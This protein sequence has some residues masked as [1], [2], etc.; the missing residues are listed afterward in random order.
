M[1][2]NLKPLFIF[3]M[4][5]AGSTLAQRILASHEEIAT[6]SEPWILLP[7]LFTL[8]EQGIYAEY[9][10]KEVVM[11]IEDFYKQLPN[12]KS[13]YLSEIKTLVMRLYAKAAKDDAKYFLDK[14]PRYHFVIEDIIGLFPEAKYIFL[15][16]HPLAVVA[17]IM[18]TWCHGKWNIYR[19]Q[20][21]IFDGLAHL[22]TAYEK[23]ASKSIAVQYE[24]L[25]SNPE[26]EFNRLFNYLEL[27]FKQELLTNF[28]KI[29]LQG[30]QGDPTGVKEYQYFSK[31]PLE[32]WKITMS[33][34]I[35]KAWCR[36][37]LR[38]IGKERLAVMGYDLDQM[39]VE[40]DSIPSNLRLMGSD[41]VRITYGIPFR[42]I[43]Y[44]LSNPIPIQRS[45][46]E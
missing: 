1:R 11:A 16:R 34:P 9:D 46:E 27:P 33:N 38:W 19:Y 17:S 41:V 14:T 2:T 29:Q 22:I 3:S 24:K 36:Y 31:E 44:Y 30:R 15:W 42:A 5:R 40:V 8:K 18:E 23:H 12:G 28:N 4:P 7:Y 6:L 32:K 37:Y 25:L 26:C 35:R 13:D 45:K 21:D 43:R 39:L 20:L 10:H